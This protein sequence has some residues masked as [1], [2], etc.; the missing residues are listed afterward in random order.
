MSLLRSFK[1]P[2]N[3]NCAIPK[4]KSLLA[5]NIQHQWQRQWI[6]LYDIIGGEIS[7][8]RG[9]TASG[10]SKRHIIFLLAVL[11]VVDWSRMKRSCLQESY[12][13]FRKD[14]NASGGFAEFQKPSRDGRS[15]MR[16]FFSRCLHI[17]QVECGC[18]SF[19]VVRVT[20]M[21]TKHCK[22]RFISRYIQ[23][24]LG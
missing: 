7:H 11:C 18:R 6:V 3:T 2:A 10:G 15:K 23:Y 17:L 16:G 19:V 5:L 8:N 12:V 24:T 4:K 20:A 13:T 14:V 22:F 9:L 21:G 1:A